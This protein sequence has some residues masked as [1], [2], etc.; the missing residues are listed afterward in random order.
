MRGAWASSGSLDAPRACQPMR[1]V[2]LTGSE[3]SLTPFSEGWALA[4]HCSED[5]SG[6]KGPGLGDR[7]L[8]VTGPPVI[9]QSLVS[10]LATPLPP[11]SVLY[12]AGK[13]S[14]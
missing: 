12:S 2:P 14:S 1:Q 13:L 10:E 5:N 8:P 7:T 11:E 6:R 4:S 3:L 9:G